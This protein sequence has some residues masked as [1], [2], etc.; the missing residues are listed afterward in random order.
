MSK[1]Q[2]RNL[3]GEVADRVRDM[4]ERGELASGERIP[5]RELCE[6]FG[7]SRTPLREAL[8]VLASEGLVELL[9]NRGPGSSS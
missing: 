5:E 1:I 4:I 6:T 9:P 3:Y 8:K 2:H 7:V